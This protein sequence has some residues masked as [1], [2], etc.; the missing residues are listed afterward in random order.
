MNDSRYKIAL[1]V[2]TVVILTTIGIQGYW[3]YK[4]YATHKDQ[5]ITDVQTSLD[6]AVDSYYANLAEKSTYKFSFKEGEINEE[7][8]INNDTVYDRILSDIDIIEHETILDT[9]KINQIEYVEVFKNIKADTILR[10][11]SDGDIISEEFVGDRKIIKSIMSTDSLKKKDFE[12]LTAKV[13]LKISNDSINIEKIKKL[14][15]DELHVKQI[16]INY[17]LFNIDDKTEREIK[18]MIDKTKLMV[19]SNSS[20]LPQN[21][22]LKLQ[23]SDI[24]ITILK[25]MF[26]G[27]GISV[28][29]VLAVISCLFYL[30]KI[31][32]NQ[33]QLAEIKNDFISNI[34]HEFK[35][36]IATISVALESI[37]N[38]NAID[39]KEKAK[40]Y[41]VMSNQQLGKL[42]TMVEKLL[43]TATLDSE[44]LEL[45]I[46]K[47]NVSLLLKNCVEKH[48][49]QTDD[50]EFALNIASENIL[51]LIDVFH[52]ENAINNLIDNAIKYGGDSIMVS[53]YEVDKF[54]TLTV[55]DNGT[56][57][58]VVEKDRIFEKFY[59]VSKGNRHDVK[60]FGIGLYYTKKIIEKHNGTID[61]KLSNDGTMFKISI[62]K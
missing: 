53:L 26:V 15:N 20:F 46:E 61:L 18:L 25:R 40:Q 9:L 6:N 24:S 48:R 47:S 28:F 34:T 31:I 13:M 57:L 39:D 45:K 16:S 17:N 30:L 44:N 2:I 36:P 23:F 51:A 37:N 60:G 33:K 3:N 41:L 32:K 54:M 11:D 58:S 55:S 4:N 19:Q 52:F 35:T 29:L 62:P 43:E 49:F 10:L 5:L 1:Y 42:N 27:I 50:V 14:L 56:T 12:L 21:A 38:F 7:V 59:R 22:N 8:I